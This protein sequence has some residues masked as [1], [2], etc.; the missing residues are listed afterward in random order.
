[1]TGIRHCGVLPRINGGNNFPTSAPPVTETRR[2]E[3]GRLFGK[4]P[5]FLKS[6][7]QLRELCGAMIAAVMIAMALRRLGDDTDRQ[8][9]RGTLG[10]GKRVH[11]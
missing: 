6:E 3:P 11:F 4:L 7:T 8:P 9:D 2:T 1:M 10:C 5:E